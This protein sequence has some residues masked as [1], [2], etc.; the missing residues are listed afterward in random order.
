ME[1]ICWEAGYL[2]CWVRS[3]ETTTIW[4]TSIFLVVI[5]EMKGGVCLHWRLGI[6]Q[7]N[8]C[9]VSHCAT[10][11]FRK[12]EWLISSR[13]LVFILI[14]KRLVLGG[15]R[16]RKNG[17]VALATLLRC[18]AKVLQHLNISNSEI[19]DEGIEA[20]APAF[21][22]CSRLK[23]LWLANNHSITSRRWQ[24]FA[25]ILESP[26]FHVTELYIS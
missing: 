5:L 11:I 10:L 16:L 17:C 7:T 2:R 25:T 22:S 9:E 3:S 13:H 21:K 8:L 23:E 20:L 1:L 15:N 4:P 18:S 24:R 12:R 26:N 14:S 19:D 6:V